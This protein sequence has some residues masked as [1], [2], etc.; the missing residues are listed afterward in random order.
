MA[1]AFVAVTDE[2]NS[3]GGGSSDKSKSGSGGNPIGTSSPAMH[4]CMAFFD[5]V[6][7]QVVRW[8]FASNFL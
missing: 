2:G 3:S 8:H 7:G 6:H 1:E 5:R 4:T